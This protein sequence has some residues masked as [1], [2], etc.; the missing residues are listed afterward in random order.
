MEPVQLPRST[1]QYHFPTAA[2][3]PVGALPSIDE[4]MATGLAE[5]FASSDTYLVDRSRHADFCSQAA[6]AGYLAVEDLTA[7]AESP[8]LKA[9]H[10]LTKKS[11]SGLGQAFRFSNKSLFKNRHRLHT[12]LAMKEVS[13]ETTAELAIGLIQ[14]GALDAASLYTT[15]KKGDYTVPLVAEAVNSALKKASG[16][17]SDS[18]CGV[19]IC[20]DGNEVKIEAHQPTYYDF[21]L[22]TIPDEFRK[23]LS[24]LLQKAVAA[25]TLHII[26][27]HVP[28]TFCG[29][30]SYTGDEL[31]GALDEIENRTSDFSIENLVKVIREIGFHNLPFDPYAVGIEFDDEA[32]TFEETSLIH[33]CD[34]LAQAHDLRTNYN[35]WLGGDDNQNRIPPLVE[36]AELAY[37]ARAL[38]ASGKPTA[39]AGAPLAQIFE[40]ARGVVESGFSF[41]YQ[42]WAGNFDDGYGLFETF[43]VKID[44]DAHT[45]V[46]AEA[47][48]YVDCVMN[49][50]GWTYLSVP[51]ER[52]VVARQL[53]TIMGYIKEVH[54]NLRNVEKVIEEIANAF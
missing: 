19:D 4:A 34:M 31:Y 2:I 10:A 36:L 37:E 6:D 13:K 26:P 16:L 43:V 47:Y 41:N 45:D 32:G 5:A 35:Y 53:V 54:S 12:T 38:G 42:D 14:A 11:V 3:S 8:T 28:A 23:E 51:I 20:I 1:G 21:D 33:G 46:Y 24:I 48:S 27:I 9:L 49:E 7:F 30:F 25:I 50:Q 18:T 15:V 40:L 44:E 52:D 29:P 17:G 39:A 22:Q